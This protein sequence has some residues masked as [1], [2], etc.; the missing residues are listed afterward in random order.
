MRLRPAIAAL[1]LAG[2]AIA[3]YLAFVKL[4]GSTAVCPTS[5]C[6]TV[7]RSRYSE[8]G[9][10]PV[11]LLGLAAYLTIFATAL[12][13]HPLAVAAGAA[14]ALAGVAFAAYLLVLQLWVIDAVCVWCASSDC[15]AALLAVLAL[16]RARSLDHNERLYG[17]TAAGGVRGGR[18]EEELLA[19]R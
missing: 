2:A 14:V 18:R 10:I 19:G 4:T 9:G 17:H 13:R 5:G 12:L 6:E 1:A 7:Q 3:A 11:S 16:L 15:V 8:L